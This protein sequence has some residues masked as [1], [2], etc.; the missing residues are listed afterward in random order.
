[1]QEVRAA[2]ARTNI[3]PPVG[4]P[5]S[6]FAGRG[7]AEGV[8]DPLYATLLALEHDGT[9]AL[10]VTGD[11]LF[12]NEAQTRAIRVEIEKKLALPGRNILLCASHTHFGPE[13][14]ASNTSA[15]VRTYL[16]SQCSQIADAAQNAFACLQPVSIGAGVGASYIGINR[17]ERNREGEIVL[18]KNP[19]GPCDREVRVVRL[20]GG[21]G[22]P[23][24]ILVNFACHPVSAT[25]S[26]RQISAD[27]VGVMRDEV[28]RQIGTTCLF[29]QGAAG[30]IN[31]IEM[32]PSFEPAH[33]LGTRLAEEVLRVFSQISTGH[34]ASL[35][36]HSQYVDLPALTFTTLNVAEQVISK[37]HAK[38]SDPTDGAWTR[39]WTK[40]RL[41]LAREMR[42]SLVSGI[43]RPPV[44]A[45]ICGL[46]LGN[47]AF[48]TT[49]GDVF[50]EIGMEIKRRSPFDHTC[51]VTH[52]NGRIHY[53]PVPAAYTEGGYEVTH[54]CR[55]DPAASHILADKCVE[56]LHRLQLCSV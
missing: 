55:V 51:F 47:T 21:D 53:V 6:G 29:F 30:N 46:R 40:Q 56:V 32:R 49:P 17:R 31:P 39:W 36:M 54:G 33:H 38:L 15:M 20:D 52:A 25:S 43:V 5:M 13:Y 19:T 27:W 8:H 7:P 1:M 48:V 10:L 3:T 45:E 2:V 16:A 11:L 42:E 50:T 44:S 35:C 34:V 23:V 24:A 12:F 26:T 37:L 41:A 28:E 9:R 18:G 14:N 22:H 4:I